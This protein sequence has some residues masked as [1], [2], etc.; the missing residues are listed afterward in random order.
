[1]RKLKYDPIEDT[2]EYKAEVAEAD[3]KASKKVEELLK[4]LV[5]ECEDDL[6]KEF[7]LSSALTSHRFAFEK[8]K[9]LNEEYGIEWKSVIEMNPGIIFD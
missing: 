8:K 5:D 6:M 3:L 7:I 9:I 4:K 2:E 1:M